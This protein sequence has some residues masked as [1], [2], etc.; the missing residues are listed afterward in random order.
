MKDVAQAARVALTGRSAS[1]PLFEVMAVLG[2]ERSLARLAQGAPSSAQLM[3][4]VGSPRRMLR[5]SALPPGLA[6]PLTRLAEP[7]VLRSRCS[8]TRR[9]RRCCRSRSCGARAGR[10]VVLPGHLARP[11]TSKRPRR[12]LG[13]APA[14]VD[15][16]PRRLPRASWPSCSRCRSTTAGGSSTTA[17][18]AVAPASSRPAAP[19]GSKLDNYDELYGYGWWA[20]ARVIGYVLVPLPLWKLLFPKDSLLDMGLRVRGFFEPHLDLRPLPRR[21]DAGDAHRRE[22]ARFRHLL[23]FLQAELAQLVRLPDVGGHVLAAVLRARAV[24]P[25]LD[26]GA[27][28]AAPWARPPSSSWPCPTA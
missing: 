1:P 5:T 18:P 25:R 12:A 22:P 9:S 7:V 2:K 15:Y 20:L 10:L 16:R 27:L 23:P 21:R 3:T 26:A 28:C 13:P 24:L 17:A 6:L 4:L 11:S 19:P 8:P 14:P